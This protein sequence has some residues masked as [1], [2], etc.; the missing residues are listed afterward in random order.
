MRPARKTGLHLSEI[1]F[2]F[3][4]SILLLLFSQSGSFRGISSFSGMLFAGIQTDMYNFF[5]N[6]SSELNFFGNIADIKT[7]RDSLREQVIALTTEKLQLQIK[8]EAT[9]SIAKQLDFDLPY[10]L[11]P[12][13]VI[14]YLEAN[15]GE[16]EIN[17]GTESGIQVG[18]VVVKGTYAVGKVTEANAKTSKVELITSSKSV[19]PVVTRKN[20]T[21]G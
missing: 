14:K 17:K 15:A 20:K 4:I 12:V 3:V 7:E 5:S 21:K 18:D 6:L 9:D 19:I 8:L 16:V 2:G 11:E 10:T 1:I 13:R